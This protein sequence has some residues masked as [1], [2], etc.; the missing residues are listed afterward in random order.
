MA[1][2]L[3]NPYG[4]GTNP[5]GGASSNPSDPYNLG[6]NQLGGSS[7]SSSL[8]GGTTAP[9]SS[10]FNLGD[11][12]NFGQAGASIYGAF[13]N[14]SPTT[15]G[16]IANSSVPLDSQQA[17]NNSQLFQQAQRAVEGNTRNAINASNA[18]AA[19]LGFGHSTAAL[20]SANI[21]QGQG[22]QQLA[23]MDANAALQSF[24]Q[25]QAAQQDQLN[26]QEQQNQLNAA[27]KLQQQNQLSK[28]PYVGSVLKYFA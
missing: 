11:L 8:L 16:S 17:F 9:A 19:K 10:G 28:I 22:S 1:D 12:A 24:Q 21:L 26:R 4:L 15:Q 25:Q 3:N 13:K 18:N 6:A 14:A 27:A 20:N 2:Y 5:L 7:S 23:S